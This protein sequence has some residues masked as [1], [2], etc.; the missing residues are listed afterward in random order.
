M[1]L[2]SDAVIGYLHFKSPVLDI[3]RMERL[4]YQFLSVLRLSSVGRLNKREY[5]I[6]GMCN[7]LICFIRLQQD[8]HQPWIRCTC[9]GLLR[10]NKSCPGLMF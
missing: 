9:Y 6:F 10:G 5:F 7:V 1:G 2:V 4:S 3:F 8:V